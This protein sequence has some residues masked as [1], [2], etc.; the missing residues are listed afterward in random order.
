MAA[1]TQRG[2]TAP[3][4]G[5]V[6]AAP[7]GTQIGDLVIVFTWERAGAGVP[8]HTRQSTFVTI[9]SHSHDDGSTDGRLSVAYK[10]ADAAGA[11]NY[12][13]YTTN[14]SGTVYTG[15]LVYQANTFDVS[16][17]PQ[18]HA[19][20]H[21]TNAQPDS[22]A[23]SP[24]LTGD[25]EILT[26][27][28]WHLSAATAVAIT[29]PTNYTEVWETA[30]S[31]DIEFSVAFRVMTGLNNTA[32]DPI[33]FTDNVSPNGSASMSI[34]IKGG[35][36]V[37]STPTIAVATFAG[38]APTA[39]LGVLSVEAGIAT[40]TFSAPSVGLGITSG[41]ATASFSAVDPDVD[42]TAS[43]IQP[44]I[45]TA[46]FIAVGPDSTLGAVSIESGIATAT[47]TA[48]GPAV[49][50]NPRPT[51]GRATFTAVAP[52]KTFGAISVAAGIALATFS[53]D[54]PI[55]GNGEA[56]TPEIA[57]HTYTALGLDASNSSRPADL[58]Y[59]RSSPWVR[60]LVWYRWRRLN[61]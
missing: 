54:V 12:Q 47:F 37:S 49:D 36:A 38:V 8:T 39:A 53:A 55:V 42:N 14:G 52:S 26:V 30:G 35:A 15:C 28:G 11:Q 1:P 41:L 58:V 7:A 51:P 23:F 24:N 20:T 40:S 60:W 25:F 56:V 33:N 5:L 31:P 10:I 9:L 59:P 16:T 44:E 50:Q 6:T 46:T 22:P 2:S 29:A 61:L 57:T 18:A 34:A 17:L 48:I 32:V 45:A 19:T 13:A 21:T 27:A 43:G 4:S 3:V